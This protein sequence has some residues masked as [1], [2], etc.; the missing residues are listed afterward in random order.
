M[1][2]LTELSET[3]KLQVVA[4]FISIAAALQSDGRRFRASRLIESL[5]G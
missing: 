1:F 5:G 2:I 3:S 4:V